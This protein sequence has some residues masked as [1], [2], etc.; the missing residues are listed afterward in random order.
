MKKVLITGSTG[1]IGIA[2]INYLIDL[3]I[4][5]TAIVR[6]FSKRLSHIPKSSLVD[7]VECDISDLHTLNL[8]KQYDVL[9]HL[10][11]EGTFG[12]A[13]NDMYTQ[14]NNIRYS[15]DAVNFAHRLGCQTF[16]FA[17][18]QAE[19]GRVEGR[20]SPETPAF[21]ETGYGMA[22][23]CAGNM[24]RILCNKFNIKH[25]WA[26]IF[27][28][29]GAYDGENTMVISTINKLLKGEVPDFTACEQQWDYLYSKDAAD[30]L[31]LMAEKGKITKF[32]VLAQGKAAHCVIL[33]KRSET[34]STLMQS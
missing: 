18:S 19:Y 20:I 16:V 1:L 3:G 5:V 24:S 23:F 8:K 29:Y 11:W 22:K 12:E 25:I 15:L 30:A 9:Y 7:I 4:E 26:R 13:R 21:P 33:L 17:G 14:S 32:I 2:L 28:I 6:P 10:G 31:F 34:I 27:S